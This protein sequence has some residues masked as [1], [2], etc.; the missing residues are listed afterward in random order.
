MTSINNNCLSL[1]T[2]SSLVKPSNIQLKAGETTIP[3]DAVIQACSFLSFKDLARMAP[4]SRAFRYVLMNRDNEVFSPAVAMQLARVKKLNNR[5]VDGVWDKWSHK[6]STHGYKSTLL[7]VKT[8]AQ[9]FSVFHSLQIFQIFGCDSYSSESI[10]AAL[11]NCPNL[12]YLKTESI[13]ILEEDELLEFLPECNKLRALEL[14]WARNLTGK[15]IGAIIQCCPNL[16]MLGIEDNN[17]L[18]DEHFEMLAAKLPNLVSLKISRNSHLT[19]AALLPFI[20]TRDMVDLN[21]SCTQITTITVESLAQRAGSLRS[22]GFSRGISSPDLSN[23]PWEQLFNNCGPLQKAVLDDVGLTD[24]ALIVLARRSPDLEELNITSNDALTDSSLTV[25][26][27][28]CPSL[29]SLGMASCHLITDV[30][31]DALH[32]LK[33]LEDLEVDR[34]TAIRVSH[35]AVERLGKTMKPDSRC[36]GFLYDTSRMNNPFWRS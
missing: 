15:S 23:A 2:D 28:S 27:S 16:T 9:I 12:T 10:I 31:I 19:D 3:E 17:N 29:K 6:F 26:A 34:G 14:G 8:E 24:S 20:S 4:T 7:K 21:V 25:V 18:Q 32:S 35:K 22:I 13:N 36:T 5:E 33:K 11:Q 30:T 1:S